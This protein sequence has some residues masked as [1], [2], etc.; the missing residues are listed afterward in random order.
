M[1]SFSD[2]A[3]AVRAE[4]PP[5]RSQTPKGSIGSVSPSD[6][7]LRS[8]LKNDSSKPREIN[9]NIDSDGRSSEPKKSPM[10]RISVTA[11][12]ISEDT[13]NDDGS[14]TAG[15]AAQPA[16]KMPKKRGTSWPEPMKMDDLDDSDTNAG[17]KSNDKKASIASVKSISAKNR[18]KA[19]KDVVKADSSALAVKSIAK[20][21][22]SDCSRVSLAKWMTLGCCIFLSIN[23]V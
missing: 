23:L 9:T 7:Q 4:S 13:L 12:T 18:K 20:E 22:W 1:V 15:T 6:V 2:D 5:A 8:I 17:K 21:K 19:D 16:P 10:V 11:D 3:P 14:E